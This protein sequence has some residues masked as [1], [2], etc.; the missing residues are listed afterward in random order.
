MRIVRGDEVRHLIT[1]EDGFRV[2]EEAY[3][4]YGRA[5]DV[6]S[7]PSAMLLMLPGDPPVKCRY[8]GA[9]LEEQGVAGARLAT[10]GHYYAWVVDFETGT[11]LGLVNEDWLHRRRTATTGAI[12][13][14]YFAPPASRVAALVGTGRIGDEVYPTLAHALAFDEF[15]VTARRFES[16]LAYAERHENDGA[17]PIR[18]VETIE[19]ALDGADVVVTITNAKE[20][21]VRPGMLKPGAFICSM[22]GV[23]ELE[24]GVLDEVDRL[25]IDDLD[26]AL[27][28]GD[29]AGWIAAGH[30]STEEI[31][32]R[33]DADIGE[34]AIG[35]K[36]GRTS[37]E[38]TILGIIQGMAICDLAM[39]KMV[40]EKAAA[41]GLG[42][43]VEVD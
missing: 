24:F 17:V 33:I 43:E 10:P 15:R 28:Q 25:I 27:L 31:V 3:R 11:P 26:Y 6:L 18:A 7:H 29:L 8:K 41:A 42:V 19:E 22:G 14:R 34:V 36:L 40:L 35:A 23:T 1:L 16:A 12:A 39:A 4:Y 13:A 21:F 32:A 20:A 9:H 5:R 38:E 37:P 30:A 2:C